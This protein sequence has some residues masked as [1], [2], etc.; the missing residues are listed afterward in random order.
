MPIW[1][2]CTACCRLKTECTL[3]NCRKCRSNHFNVHADNYYCSY[4]VKYCHKWHDSFV[5]ASNTLESSEY[6]K[7]NKNHYDYCDYPCIPFCISRK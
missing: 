6:N 3:K 2:A 5:R 7:C 4:Y 1:T